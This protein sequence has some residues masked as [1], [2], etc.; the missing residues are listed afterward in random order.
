MTTTTKKVKSCLTCSQASKARGSCMGNTLCKDWTAPAGSCER[1]L[2]YLFC[3]NEKKGADYICSMYKR[4][5]DYSKDT[6]SKSITEEEQLLTEL[7]HGDFDDED[8]FNLQLMVRNVTQSE[9]IVPPDL[10]VSDSDFPTAANFLEFCL[11]NDYLNVQ[12]FPKQ[13]EA[14]IKLF[15]D[16]CPNCNDSYI[17]NIPFNATL[18]EIES[19]IVLFRHG[20]CPVCKGH[21]D[22][23]LSAGLLKSYNELAG[24]AGQRGGKSAFVAMAVSY[25]SHLLLKSQNPAKLYNLLSNS[26][27]HGTVVALTFAQAKASL[28][29]PIY[30]YMCDTPWFQAYNKHVADISAREG[31]ELI[32][33][34]DTFILYRHRNLL[35]S[36]SGP[37][38]KTLRGY[39]RVWAAIDEI[40]WFDSGASKLVKANANEVH[41]ALGRSLLTVRSAARNRLQEGHVVPNGILYNVSSPSNARDKIVTLYRQSQ[42]PNSRIYGFWYSSFELN[43]TL[44][45]A[46]VQEE[47][48]ADPIAAR[49]DYLAVPPQATAPFIHSLNTLGVNMSNRI[50][51]VRL[52]HKVHTAKSGV[53]TT[54]ATGD[55]NGCDTLIPKVLAID[56]GY[57]NNSFAITVASIQGDKMFVDLFL[58][59]IP[60]PEQP[61]NHSLI[62]E[63]LIMRMIKRLNVVL[64]VADR[65]QSIKLLQDIERTTN[66]DTLTYSVVYHD[67]I[68]CR[69][70]MNDGNT[71]LPRAEM[72]KKAIETYTLERYPY[73]FQDKPVSHFAFQC[74]TVVDLQ[75]TVDKGDG[76]TDDI[77]RSFVLAHAMLKQ[78]SELFQSDLQRSSGVAR[79]IAIGAMSSLSG[80]GSGVSNSSGN[81]GGH[82]IAIGAMSSLGRR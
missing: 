57:S 7:E 40:G 31:V 23:F 3:P 16:W 80:G 72:T 9:G 58:E 48:D 25:H 75:K 42:K 81:G 11:S 12:P 2:T 70:A 13:V 38:M 46:D 24:L 6:H 60:K 27:L 4:N 43:P 20:V 17:H 5:P 49:R 1:C 33:L 37:N 67:F 69:Q 73:Y 56:A 68:T 62:V 14:G 39:T 63:E 41:H 45:Q 78:H 34:K 61:L 44:T 53:E 21:K 30:G 55:F 29:D 82:T 10:K 64:V 18:D 77:F 54:Y 71:S 36:P 59:V 74:I 22:K 52:T 66:A 50:N 15:S 76:S 8:E 28:W 65:W 79:E 47:F 26:V 35:F 19:R 51:P 32:K